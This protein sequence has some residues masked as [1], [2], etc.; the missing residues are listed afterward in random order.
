MLLTHSSSLIPPTTQIKKTLPMATTN[1][2]SE[3]L[4]EV[5]EQTKIILFV[6][7]LPIMN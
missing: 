4:Y 3:S 5:W 7:L 2:N 1:N 6:F